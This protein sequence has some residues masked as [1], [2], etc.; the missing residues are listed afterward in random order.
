M[1]LPFCFECGT[2]GCGCAVK[3]ATVAKGA[4]VS[5][6]GTYR[7][8]L[9]RTWDCMPMVGWIMLNPST[10][11]ADQDDPTIRKCI[12]FAKRWGCGGIHVVNLFAFR[13]TD[14]SAL[15][16]A[17]DPV[18]P[19][20]D[21]NLMDVFVR[22]ERVVAAWGTGGSRFGRGRHLMRLVEACG[23]KLDALRLTKD[24]HPGHPLYVP[25]DT[26]LI[27]LVGGR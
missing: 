11:D 16:A 5:S 26:A 12:G 27:P 21:A 7:Y 13:A 6:C 3:R 10:A 8:S 17:D 22:C 25:Y 14:P 20:N 18:G 15:D 9:T 19:R 24:G 4:E 1:T 2:Q 23:Q